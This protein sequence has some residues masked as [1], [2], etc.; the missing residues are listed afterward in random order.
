MSFI[1]VA[2]GTRTPGHCWP[3]VWPSSPPPPPRLQVPVPKRI[4]G[5]GPLAEVGQADG[6]VRPADPRCGIPV[7]P[8]DEEEGPAPVELRLQGRGTLD[9]LGPPNDGP[10]LGHHAAGCGCVS[11]EGGVQLEGLQQGVLHAAPK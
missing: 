7:T 8:H 3:K 9:V 4:L 11:M 5:A 6:Q 1:Y 10:R 2:H